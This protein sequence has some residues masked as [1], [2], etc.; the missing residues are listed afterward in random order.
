MTPRGKYSRYNVVMYRGSVKKLRD[1]KIAA[2]NIQRISRG[3]L[4]RKRVHR[5]KEEKQAAAHI[6][7]ISRGKIAR[8]QVAKMKEEK[9]AAKK[10]KKLR[11][12]MQGG[13]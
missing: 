5:I 4:A 10:Y 6:Q 12:A 11:E 1:E 7:R 3:K 13:G 8:R 2:Q 9:D